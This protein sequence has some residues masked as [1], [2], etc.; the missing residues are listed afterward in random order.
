MSPKTA[1][2]TAVIALLVVVAYEHKK[3]GGTVASFG[4]G[5]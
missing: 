2:Y 4:R 5:V 1:A 3:A